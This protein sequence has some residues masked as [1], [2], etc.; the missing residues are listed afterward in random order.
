MKQTKQFKPQLSY[1]LALRP[2][3]SSQRMWRAAAHTGMLGESDETFQVKHLSRSLAH[4]NSSELLL[5]SVL[6]KLTVQ[7]FSFLSSGVSLFLPQ[8]FFVPFP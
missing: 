5:F 4:V 7:L 8:L 6:L 2:Y 3:P 1:H